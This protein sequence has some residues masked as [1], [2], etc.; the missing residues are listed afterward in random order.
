MCSDGLSDMLD[1]DSISHI[2]ASDGSLE[3]KSVQLVDAANANGG[4]DNIS[5][6]LALANSGARKKGLIS[7]WLGQ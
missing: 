6:L 5:V 1:D 4:R 3:M 7:R 2:L